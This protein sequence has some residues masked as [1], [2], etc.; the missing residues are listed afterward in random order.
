MTPPVRE[1]HYSGMHRLIPARYSETGTVLEEVA[2]DEAM[3]ADAARLDAATNERI[4][5]ELYGLGGIS[6]FELVYGIPGSQIIRAAFLHP[7]PFGGRFNDA[8][9]GAWYAA[10]RVETAVAEVAYH[11]AKRLSEMEVFGLPGERPDEEVSSYDDW[12][13]DFHGPFHA[14][15]PAKDYAELLHPEPVP[16]CYAPSQA[17]ARQLLGEQSNGILYSSVRHRG[18]ACLAC[19]RPALV[20]QPRRAE[21]YELR[22]R[23]TASGYQR[24]VRAV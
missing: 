5:G 16:Q 24:S 20:Y 19:F 11:K 18:G 15:E 9:R 13:A 3:L 21:R 1:V 6:N 2:E 23:A 22:L 12:Q 10:K 4:Q 14:L 8:T 7:G 17:L